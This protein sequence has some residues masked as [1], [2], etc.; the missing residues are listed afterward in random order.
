MTLPD[1]PQMNRGTRALQRLESNGIAGKYKHNY[2]H[3]GL[4]IYVTCFWKTDQG[5]TFGIS[6]NIDFKYSSLCKSLVIDCS[7]S[8]YIVLLEQSFS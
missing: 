8:R 6:R 7:H 4:C 1:E 3:L 2:S 5:V